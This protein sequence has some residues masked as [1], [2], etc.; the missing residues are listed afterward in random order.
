MKRIVQLCPS[1]GMSA[2]FLHTEPPLFTIVPVAF[3]GLVEA[4]WVRSC[5]TDSECAEAE[6]ETSTE[7][8]GFVATSLNEPC[9]MMASFHEYVSDSQADDERSHWRW[10]A[11][12][13]KLR[14]GEKQ[15]QSEHVAAVLQEVRS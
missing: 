1:N 4:C 12:A 10:A 15:K 7:V 9:E 5:E 8:M 2:V 3:W 11:A 6:H 14:D 13:E